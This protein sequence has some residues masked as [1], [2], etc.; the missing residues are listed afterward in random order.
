[1]NLIGP[2][3]LPEGVILLCKIAEEILE[4]I[5]NAISEKINK[6]FFYFMV[7]KIRNLKE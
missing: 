3:Y 6:K 1:M 5:P 4:K 2:S 7:K